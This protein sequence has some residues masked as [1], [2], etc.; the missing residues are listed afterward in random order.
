MDTNK[1]KE[2]AER[3]LGSTLR[4]VTTSTESGLQKLP[5]S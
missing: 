1:L 2:L 3:L 5:A 4:R